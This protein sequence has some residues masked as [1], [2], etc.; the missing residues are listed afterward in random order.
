MVRT[1]PHLIETKSKDC[2]RSKIDS[3][4]DNG[5]YIFRELT[6]RDYGVD[7]LIECFE[8]G[9]PTGKIGFLQIKGTDS[10]ITPLKKSPVVSCGNISVSN[11]HYAKQERISV[12]VIYVSLKKERPM[13]YIDLREAVRDISYSEDAKSVTIHIPQENYVYNDIS[14]IL[15]I[16]DSYYTKSK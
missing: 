4:G 1:Q 13:Y 6:E 3:F 14:P 11:L 12:I 16:I 15:S 8:G 7:A 2:V 5:D 9:N 10:I